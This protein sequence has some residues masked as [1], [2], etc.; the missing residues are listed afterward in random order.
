MKSLKEISKNSPLSEEDLTKIEKIILS[1]GDF[2]PEIVRNE[3]DLFCTKLGMADYYFQTTPLETIAGHIEALKAAEIIALLQK[4]KVLEIDYATEGTDEAIYLVDDQ[5][6]RAI[7]IEKKIEEKYPFFRIQSYRTQRKV[8]GIEHIRMYIVSKPT[9]PLDKIKEKETDIKK[10]ADK[11]FIE[12]SKKETIKRYEK[13]LKKSIEEETP[14]IDVSHKEETGE[15]RIM[16]AID[17]KA[18]RR[19]L[20]NVSDVFNSHNLV[21]NRKYIEQFA[22]GKTVFVFY[23]PD[24]K[25]KA[26]IQDLV[27]DISLIYVIPESPLTEL[28][29]SGKLSAQETVFGVSAWSFAHQF[30]TTHN[31]E[32]LN[33]SEHLKDAPE[34]MGILRDM[35]IKLAKDTYTEQRV[36]DAFLAYPDFLKKI[37]KLFDKKFN[38]FNQK[39]DISKEFSEIEN[40]L[41]QSIPTDIDRN[42]FK[43]VLLFISSILRTNFFKKQK[44]SLAFMYKPGFLNPVDYPESTFGVFHVI[45]TEMRGFHIRF[46]DIARGG[47]RIVRSNSLQ[48]YLFNSD[49]IFDENYNLARTQQKKNKDIPEGGS[50]GTVLLHWGYQDQAERA[51]KKYIHGLLDLL[52][53]SEEILDGYG[54]EVILFLGPDEGTADLMAWASECARKRN[55]PYWKAFSTGKPLSMGGIPHDLYGMTTNSVHQY[56]LNILKKV[57]QKEKEI[58][59]VMTGGPDGDLGSNEILISKDK[60]LAIIDSSGVLYDPQGIDRKELTRLAKERVPVEHFKKE[61]ISNKGFLVSIK[62]ENVTL[63][64]GEKVESGLEFRNAF[65]LDPRFSADLFVPCGGRPATININNWKNFIKEDGEPRFKYIVEGANLFLT[66]E[67]RLRLEEK[68]VVIYKDASANKGGV[69]SSSLEVFVSLAMNDEEFSRH[70][71]VKN[72]NVPAFRKRY[73]QEII[74]I[75]KENA[76]LEFEIIWRENQKNKIS[77]S[78]LTDL[79]SEKINAITDAIYE[80]NLSENKELFEKVIKG[81]CPKILIEEIGLE[82]IIQR[83]PDSYLRA[84]F[85][86]RLASRYIYTYGLDANEINFFNFLKEY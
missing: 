15:L 6:Y 60:I 28:F 10:I 83:V 9:F 39:H 62:D 26:L 3:I 61:L 55:Y 82:K 36:W 44:V 21:S 50:K 5:H 14:Q 65:H 35:K 11:K 75:I 81:Y 13:I 8:A 71:C 30:L 7:E 70:M 42:I 57:G 1:H 20:V 68:G 56:V 25:N 24:I 29:R 53:P 80:S 40:Q 86:S 49:F 41:K 45:A 51:F 54:Q 52:L 43:A 58:T 47:I 64:G 22:N 2:Q 19:F 66:Q 12:T 84:V 85:A 63:P 16:V 31:E 17:R 74:Q 46:R 4:E 76:S 32:Y 78:I 79:I 23:L 73:I 38:P 27:D 69:T 77:R 72:G 37:F 59:K 18:G 48:N 33:L 67:A 34:M